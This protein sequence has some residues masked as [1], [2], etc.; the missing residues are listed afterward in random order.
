[1][2]ERYRDY[3]TNAIIN[4]FRNSK[5]LWS[6]VSSLLEPRQLS[7]TSKH[8]ADDFANHFRNKVDNTHTAMQN[9]LAAVIQPCATP[10]LDVFRPTTSS[11]VSKMI[12][13]LPTWLVKRLCPVAQSRASASARVVRRGCAAGEPEARHRQTAVEEAR[14]GSGRP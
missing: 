4:N 7:S 1:M 13:R 14:T 3:W 12:M 5:V 10:A 9:S 8:T 2:Q 11:E 6:K